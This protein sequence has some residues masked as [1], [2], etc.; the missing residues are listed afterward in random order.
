MR[1]IGFAAAVEAGTSLLRL[2]DPSLFVSLLLGAELSEAGP[3][4]D[5]LAGITLLA[6]E[7]ACRPG[8]EGAGPTDPA[9][10]GLLVVSLLTTALRAYLGLATQL[11]G[12][13]LWSAA[14]LHAVVSILLPGEARG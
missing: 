3:A 2:I 6:L 5:R 12:A 8:G 14:A 9:R 7:V 13:L 4:L 10:W 1:V 11:V